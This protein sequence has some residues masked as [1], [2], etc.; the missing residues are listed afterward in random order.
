MP[1]AA[2]QFDPTSHPGLLMQGAPNVL[3]EGLCAARV[4]DL[5]T[6]MLPP[7]A[8]PHPPTPVVKGS[9]TVLINNMP[10]ARMGDSSGCGAV[11]LMGA[12]TVQ[13]GG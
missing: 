4:G 1:A 10:A 2:R 8:G 7:V 12:A 13:I 5:H 6:C 3:I 9:A 11:I